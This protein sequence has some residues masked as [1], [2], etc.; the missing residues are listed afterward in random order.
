PTQ[1][2]E[3]PAPPVYLPL[4]L[5]DAISAALADS[6]VVRTL[7]GSVNVASITPTDVIMAGQQI[8]VERGRFQPRLTGNL[9]AS[10]INQPPNS[11][12]GPGISANTRRDAT[13]AR[14]RISQPLATGG[15]ISMGIEPATAYLFFPD[16]VNPGQFNPL[17]STDFVVRVKQPVLQGAGR[18][19]NLAP[20]RIS[21]VRSNQSRWQL[22][23]V[24]NSQIRSVTEA[25][26][27]LYAAHLQ[28]QAVN[29]VLPL[30]E[31]SVRV[32]SLRM[33]VDRSIPADVARAQVQ[34]DGFRRSES[35]VLGQMRRRSLQLRQLMGGDP[36]ILPLLLP[37][38]RPLEILP[39]EDPEEFIQVAVQNRPLLNQMRERVNEKRILWDVS[40]NRVL[41]SLDLRGDYWMNGLS[42]RLDDSFRQVG[43][44][45]YADWTL[46]FGVDIPIG[47]KTASSQRRI[48]ELAVAREQ[49]LL[50]ATEKQVAFE[51]AELVSDLQAAWQRMEIT[52]RQA[53][54]TQE[55]LRVSR[56]RYTQPPAANKSQDWLLLALTDLQSAMRAY[57]DAIGN[58][59]EAIADYST[60]QVQLQQAQGMSTYEWQQQT[61]NVAQDLFYSGHSGPNFHSYRSDPQREWQILQNAKQFK[62][63]GPDYTLH[64]PEPGSLAGHSF[65][66]ATDTYSERKTLPYRTWSDLQ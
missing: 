60:L 56:I 10:H 46:G 26:W 35:S 30:A 9:D 48:A 62:D 1:T 29:A 25:Y 23:E 63:S 12:F 7:D 11:F 37:L 64:E 18:S 15:S 43:T 33:Q 32:E 65:M 49:V 8:E 19:V 21:Q 58:V 17:Y 61:D 66:N 53:Q 34:L 2:A 16:G 6:S 54:E 31:E 14:V 57:V 5:R 39:P 20:I 27:Q 24:L 55:W 28:V 47:N 51:I 38:E 44:G 13:D 36:Q 42:N 22:E 50:A 52:K 4:T 40:R 3:I 41:P 59:G 45:D